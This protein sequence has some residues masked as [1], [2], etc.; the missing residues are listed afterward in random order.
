MFNDRSLFLL[1]N[2][3][4]RS[5]SLHR[6]EVRY[7]SSCVLL[8]LPPPRLDGQT[9]P[10]GRRDKGSVGKKNVGCFDRDNARRPGCTFDFLPKTR[11]EVLICHASIIPLQG[12][13]TPRL[14]FF[15]ISSAQKPSRIWTIFLSLMIRGREIHIHLF[16]RSILRL[17]FFSQIAVLKYSD[18]LSWISRGNFHPFAFTCACDKYVPST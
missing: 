5:S 16:H 15:G 12:G 9:H 18:R 10:Q 2:A 4:L 11:R 1:T 7:D 6:E 3:T 8:D 13:L 14:L 17:A